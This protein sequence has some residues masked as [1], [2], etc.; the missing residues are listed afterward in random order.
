MFTIFS[1][2]VPGNMELVYKFQDCLN[3]DVFFVD[4]KPN[5]SSIFL[6]NFNDL[7]INKIS[8]GNGPRCF[9]LVK[10]KITNSILDS[11][12]SKKRNQISLN[13][14]IT[15]VCMNVEMIGRTHITISIFKENVHLNGKCEL[16]FG[17]ITTQ[18][19]VDSLVGYHDNFPNWIP[20]EIKNTKERYNELKKEL[21]VIDVM[22]S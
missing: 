11:D 12:L 5:N 8:F 22:C 1:E 3:K 4:N 20:K 17:F 2:I 7:Y 6:K 16:E 13:L 15:E 10:V 14:L 21:L 18:E 9:S 19:A